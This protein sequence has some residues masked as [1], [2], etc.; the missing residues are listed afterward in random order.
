MDKNRL[1]SNPANPRERCYHDEKI[2]WK[3]TVSK[4]TDQDYEKEL[5]T[6]HAAFRPFFLLM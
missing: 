3:D 5:G 6:R 1:R 2:D 4:A